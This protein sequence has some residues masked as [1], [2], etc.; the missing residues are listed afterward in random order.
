MITKKTVATGLFWSG[1]NMFARL[2][3]SLVIKLVLAYYLLPEHFGLIGMAA[4]AMALLQ[5]FADMGVGSAL[6]QKRNEDLQPIHWV[7]AYWF[8]IAVNW[9]C[10]ALM[11]FVVSPLSVVF[12]GEEELSILIIG[13]SFSLLLNP[14]Y[15]VHRVRLNKELKFRQTFIVNFTG[16][17]FGGGVGILMAVNGFGALAFVGQGLASNFVILPLFRL[18]V[19][20]K[21]TYQFSFHHILDLMSFGMYDVGIRLFGYAYSHLN[22]LILGVLLNPAAVGYFVFARSLTLAVIDPINKLFRKVFF[23]FFSNIQVDRKRIKRYH[24]TQIRYVTAFVFPFCAGVIL[25]SPDIL[26]AV[27]GEKWMAAVF[28]VRILSAFVAVLATGGTPAV[29]LKSVGKVRSVLNLQ[30]IRFF[31]VKIPFVFVGAK[32]Y[33]FQG[34]LVM[35]LLS[36]VVILIIDYFFVR[37]AIDLH[38]REFAI[39]I[40]N[41]V[42]GTG[43]MVLVLLFFTTDFPKALVPQPC[44]D[45]FIGIGIYFLAFFAL[46]RLFHK[47]YFPVAGV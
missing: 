30:I 21:S 33:G 18:M 45:V 4:A 6:I 32:L 26:Y 11:V 9:V 31:V 17:I 42:L 36:Q 41:P 1:M 16:H 27:W 44:F 37:R 14:F 46:N 8:N 3:M 22:I 38:L 10:F 5:V 40:V 2:G 43:I 29:V 39:Q 23:P 13:L 20:W 35:L 25:L 19:R 24:L 28:P 34:F 12:F 15:F 7:S 47:T